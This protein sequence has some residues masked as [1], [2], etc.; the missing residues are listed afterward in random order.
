M[1][2]VDPKALRSNDDLR[3]YIVRGLDAVKATL[4]T[5][6]VASGGR[7][8]KD[9]DETTRRTRHKPDLIR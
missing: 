8:Y 4:D 7:L 6:V 2:G 5:M 3:S 9:V 1:N